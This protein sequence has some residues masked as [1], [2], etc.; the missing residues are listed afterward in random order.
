MDVSSLYL[1][2]AQ[3]AGDGAAHSVV[4]QAAPDWLHLVPAGV[5]YGRDGRGPYKVGN[6]DAVIAASM[7]EGKIALDE[8]HA[9]DFA[10][11][12]G[13]ASP[14]RGWFDRLEARADGIWGHVE[15]NESGAAL[16]TDKAYRGVSPVFTH[17]KDGSVTRILRAA[18]TNTPNIAQ[19]ATLHSAADPAKPSAQSTGVMMELSTVRHALGLPDTADEAACL[20]A[21]NAQR[22]TVA[23]QSEQIATFGKTTVPV[24][25]VIALQTE[26]ATIKQGQAHDKAVAVIDA[27][28][29]AGKPIVA[30]REQLIAQH[31]S[32]PAT[33]ETLIAGMPSIHAARGGDG[34]FKAGED[35]EMMS[36]EDTAVCSKMGIEPGA[37]KAWRK[38]Q[39]E[40]GAN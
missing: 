7:A 21:M 22:E 16:M 11:T 24:D 29:A 26:I 39:R 6:A 9:T 40:K 36:S 30:V 27:A 17:S 34:K 37:F 33:V 20:V 19:L 32:D 8:N 38:A 18:L 5:F 2:I 28:I 25:R 13:V 12:T 4:A 31:M 10:Q 35:P 23:R 14:A 1:G 15:W 3:P